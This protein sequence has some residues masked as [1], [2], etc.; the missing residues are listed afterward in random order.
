MSKSRDPKIFLLV[1]GN[2]IVHRAF[3]ALPVALTSPDG[4]P[5]NAVFG[6]ARILISS[7]KQFK[8]TYAAVAFDTGKK[9]FRDDLFEQYKAKRTPAPQ[10]LYDQIPTVQ[11]MLDALAIPHIG[12]EGFEADDVIGTLS[13]H[14]S[15]EYKDIEVIVLTGDGDTL[16]LVDR[17][18][19][20]AMPQRGIQPPT[21][22]NIAAVEGK[23]GLKPHQIIDYK[24][25]RGDS[26]D[27]IPGVAGIGE[28]TATNLLQEF[29]SVDEIYKNLDKIKSESTV[30]KLKKGKD[31]AYLSQKLATIICDV[32]FDF[33]LQ[34]AK[35]H[36]YDAKKAAQFFNKLGMKSI[37]ARLPGSERKDGEQA[38]LF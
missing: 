15:H 29:G 32:P 33:S 25:L 9:T 23:Y 30:N 24:A 19:K 26:S 34:K 18:T 1:D 8:P 11:K 7:L 12:K 5:S 36:D 20:V 13:H 10:E 6:F 2:A 27:N 37:V 3:H 14:I 28:K 22:Y 17:Q 38:A 21:L 31:M 35:V 16:Q 4:K